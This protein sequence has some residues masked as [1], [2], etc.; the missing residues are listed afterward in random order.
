VFLS[1]NPYGFALFYWS[2]MEKL[3]RKL[4]ELNYLTNEQVRLALADLLCTL[5]DEKTAGIKRLVYERARELE[6]A[7]QIDGVKSY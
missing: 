3:R 4:R 2:F 1:V 5:P 6:T 7:D